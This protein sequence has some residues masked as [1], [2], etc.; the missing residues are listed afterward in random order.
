MTYEQF[1][2]YNKKNKELQLNKFTIK[3]VDLKNNR[4]DID[5]LGVDLRTY[6]YSDS[7]YNMFQLIIKGSAYLSNPSLIKNWKYFSTPKSYVTRD[8]IHKIMPSSNKKVNL[9]FITIDTDKF[10]S[11]VLRQKLAF[12]YK[13]TNVLGFTIL[14]NDK[15]IVVCD[16]KPIYLEKNASNLFN[17]T[18]FSTINLENVNTTETINVDNM[19]YGCESEY[20]NLKGVDFSHVI[21]MQYTFSCMENLKSLDVS[22]LHTINVEDMEGLFAYSNIDNLNI[23][24]L[25]TRNCECFISMF[26]KTKIL[27][28][29]NFS[30]FITTKVISMKS[31]FKSSNIQSIIGIETFDTVNVKTYKDMFYEC[32]TPFINVSSFKISKNADLTGMFYKVC[33]GV[34]DLS[35]FDFSNAY[36]LTYFITNASISVLNISSFTRADYLNFKTKALTPDLFS[37]GYTLSAFLDVNRINECLM[38]LDIY[39]FYQETI[40]KDSSLPNKIKVVKVVS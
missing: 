4:C 32:N 33:T 13:E 35:G 9:S 30:S 40:K 21:S 27:C 38:N 20:L 36:D 28:P 22:N 25:D 31:M 14:Y 23:V 29:L 17:N 34:L 24:G 3:N 10:E 6:N 8:L 18:T 39:N 1:L 12:R 15:D 37:Y 19:F 16:D 2:K 5:V 11:F 26:E 7:L